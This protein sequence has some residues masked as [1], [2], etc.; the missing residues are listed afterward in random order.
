MDFKKK[1]GNRVIGSVEKSG[2]LVVYLLCVSPFRVD[3]DMSPRKRV[4]F[5]MVRCHT[6]WEG[7]DVCVPAHIPGGLGIGRRAFNSLH[8]SISPD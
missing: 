5:G 7:V 8:Y 4:A 3:V 2:G 1:E 6:K